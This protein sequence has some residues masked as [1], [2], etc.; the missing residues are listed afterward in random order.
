[1]VSDFQDRARAE[2]WDGRGEDAELAWTYILT[3]DPSSQ[4]PVLFVCRQILWSPLYEDPWQAAGTSA[5]ARSG[6]EDGP[7]GELGCGLT[8]RAT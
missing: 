3:C 8:T 7:R 1:M 5:S 2:L 4:V 6:R